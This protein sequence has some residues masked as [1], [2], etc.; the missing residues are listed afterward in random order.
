MLKKIIPQFIRKKV[1]KF[2]HKK[3]A[4]V[5]A[6][7]PYQINQIESNQRLK[8]QIAIV[9]GG[10]GVIGRSIACRLAIDGAKVYVCGTTREKAEKVVQEIIALGGEAVSCVI[11]FFSETDIKEKIAGIYSTEKRIDILINSA[12]GSSREKNASIDKLPTEVIDTILTV[13]LRGTILCCREA[14]KYMLLHKKGKIVCITSVIGDK[15]K[16][17]FSEYAAAKAGIIAFVKSIAMELGP[18][19]I[20]VNCVSP[21][22]V[23]RGLINK[24]QIDKLKKTNYLDDYGRPEDIANMVGFLVSGE[25]EFVTGQNFI[26]DG[27]R[28]LGLKGD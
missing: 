4:Y 12:G 13:N 16:A 9:I 22:I 6:S 25:A 3:F 10:S 11:D 17:R 15:G 27:G 20:R 21:G 24:E 23:Q 8:N 7:V 18:K 19:G 28:S 2:L 14:S 5:E 1:N 26:V